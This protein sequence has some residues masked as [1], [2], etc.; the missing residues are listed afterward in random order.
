MGGGVGFAAPGHGSG[1]LGGVISIEDEG[2]DSGFGGGFRKFATSGFGGGWGGAD[3]VDLGVG[4]HPLSFGSAGADG[5]AM[6]GGLGADPVGGLGA[7]FL[8]VSGSERYDES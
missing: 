3:S 5:A 6:V 7:V 4:R 2:R 8:D 1:A